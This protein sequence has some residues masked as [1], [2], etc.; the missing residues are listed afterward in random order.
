MESEFDKIDE[1]GGGQVLF[2]EFVKWALEKNLDIEDDVDEETQAE[3]AEWNSRPMAKLY[4]VALLCKVFY[5]TVIKMVHFFI[6]IL[7]FI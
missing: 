1:N 7:Q 2:A 4:I 3:P 5:S 6:N